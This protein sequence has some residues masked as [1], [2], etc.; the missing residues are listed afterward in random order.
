MLVQ[1]ASLGAG[2]IVAL[3]ATAVH[4]F[5]AASETRFATKLRLPMALSFLAPCATPDARLA[6]LPAFVLDPRTGRYGRPAAAAARPAKAKAK[7]RL[8]VV[9]PPAGA[10]P[11][12]A[13]DA[14]PAAAE[15]APAKDPAADPAPEDPAGG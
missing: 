11:P 14:P 10:A 2:R 12:A 1:H 6:E 13:E 7:P 3:D 15:D 8:R 5:F 4:V 9:K